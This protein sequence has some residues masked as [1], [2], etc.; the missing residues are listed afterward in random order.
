MQSKNK[1]NNTKPLFQA[2]FRSNCRLLPETSDVRIRIDDQFTVQ[3]PRLSWFRVGA[4]GP[5]TRIPSGTM[6]ISFQDHSRY[7]SSK[8]D[9]VHSR[10]LAPS[11]VTVSGRD[12]QLIGQDR[13]SGPYRRLCYRFVSFYSIF[14]VFHD[15]IPSIG[16]TSRRRQ[17]ATSILSIPSPACS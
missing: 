3:V 7:E 2:P 12:Q 13:R 4:R 15:C 16:F 6:R 1:E 17:Q 8:I 9:Q 10:S 11:A 5:G 14:D